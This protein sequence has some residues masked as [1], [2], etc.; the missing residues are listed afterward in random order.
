MSEQQAIWQ[1]EC[2]I[3]SRLGAGADIQE[4]ILSQLG[5]NR[6][7]QRDVFAVQLAIEEALVNAIKHGNR[8]DSSREVRIACQLFPDR[9]AIAI[10]DEGSGFDPSLV[11]DPTA[12]ENLESPCG[13]GI[14][15]M[16]SFMSRV[17]FA[18]PGNSVLMEKTRTEPG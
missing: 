9:V 13:R 3:P 2:G 18:P 6:W 15:L 14:M 1:C 12:P 4:Q 7:P 8:S 11:P 5:R 17:E 10:T 16:R